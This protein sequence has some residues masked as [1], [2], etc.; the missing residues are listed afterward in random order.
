MQKNGA[1]KPAMCTVPSYH[2]WSVLVLHLFS[3]C[4]II[5][6]LNLLRKMA[7]I[8]SKDGVISAL[9]RVAHLIRYVRNKERDFMT[10]VVLLSV[11]LTQ[12]PMK[13]LKVIK[14]CL[15]WWSSVLLSQWPFL[16]SGHCAQI[17]PL[18]SSPC[19]LPSYPSYPVRFLC[20]LFCLAA[21]FTQQKQPPRTNQMK[22]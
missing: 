21:C 16:P 6:L 18:L 4:L 2:W 9:R 20:A 14:V 15:H 10:L 22:W 1:L 8:K 12:E 3:Y 11:H 17:A 7:Q 5:T 13:R 19:L